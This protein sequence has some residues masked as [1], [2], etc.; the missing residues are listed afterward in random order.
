MAAT[1]GIIGYG[2][3]IPMGRLSIEDIATRRGR[4]ENPEE[5]KKGFRI[6]SKAVPGSDEDT[7]TIAI[8]AAKRAVQR[9]DINATEI[10][11]ITVGSESHPYAVKPTATIVGEA[12]GVGNDYHAADLE[13]ACKAGTAGLQFVAAMVAARQI[14]IGLAIG[15]D[16]SQSRHGDA[17]EYTAGAGGAAFLIGQKK[18][19]WIASIDDTLSVSSDTPDF[20]RH[21]HED[22]PRHAER[23]TGEPAYFKHVLLATTRLLERNN[24][25]PKDIH[26]VVF[27]MPN[28]KFPRL[29]AKRLGFSESQLKAGLVVE[30]MGNAYSGMVPVGLSSVLDQARANQRIVVTSY[31]S[32]AG[33]D[34][35]LLTTTDKLAAVRRRA[36]RVQE[37]LA[38]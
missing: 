8:E 5:L 21:A 28:G 9:A 16:C 12:L 30:T 20:W 25:E 32:G 27:H 35:F 13:F 17:L 3:S 2:A 22:A 7:A 37:L 6:T 23:F 31:G 15:A 34:A 36:E 11:A 33:S 29:A 4:G 1:A 38:V 10:G 14:K 18:G 26:H 24:L 19:D